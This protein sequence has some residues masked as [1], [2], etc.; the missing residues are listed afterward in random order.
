MRAEIRP[1]PRSRASDTTRMSS[2]SIP[3]APSI[4]VT[5]AACTAAPAGRFEQRWTT[6]LPAAAS[7]EEVQLAAI[8][9][10]AL[11]ATA[12]SDGHGRCDLAPTTL[13]RIGERGVRWTV[14]FSGPTKVVV[15]PDQTLYAAVGGEDA[16]TLHHLDATGKEL[17]SVAVQA[18][19]SYGGLVLAMGDDGDLYLDRRPYVLR[20][21]RNGS[22]VW[23]Q[24]YVAVGHAFVSH[25]R[26]VLG[27]GIVPGAGLSGAASVQSGMTVLDTATGA[28]V[29]SSEEGPTP[30]G[31]DATGFA[32]EADL[33]GGPDGTVYFASS[34]DARAID[35]AGHERWRRTDRHA[36]AL[37]LL[38][39]G[40]LAIG[41]VTGESHGGIEL[42]DPSTGNAPA[43]A[44]AEMVTPFTF[45][46]L[47]YRLAAAANG[48]LLVASSDTI[49]AWREVGDAR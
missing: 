13:S 11:V 7:C 26:L 46:G 9:E 19:P 10:E 15:A 16:V 47:T 18:P 20:V 31:D 14:P 49:S 1:Q 17:S 4:L 29:W 23:T 3:L 30:V 39:S 38:P 27:D 21:H 28:V 43:D 40:A 12:T 33:A 37:A 36:T 32:T 8:D 34:A 22:V 6:D 5:L 35:R 45:L 42:V 44:S 41:Y 2:R 25:D 48:D 24:S